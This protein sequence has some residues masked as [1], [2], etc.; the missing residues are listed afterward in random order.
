MLLREV[1]R[2]V[3]VIV[4]TIV[5]RR[6]DG[7]LHLGVQSLDR[8]RQNVRAGVPVRLAVR[9]IFKRVQI[10]FGHKNCSLRI[11]RGKDKRFT[12][13]RSGVKRHTLH[14]STLLTANAVARDLCNGRARPCLLGFSSAARKW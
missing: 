3:K 2:R 1:E 14:G 7:Q 4:K 8:L 10:L 9:F 5:D 11:F 13:D 6:A 12:P